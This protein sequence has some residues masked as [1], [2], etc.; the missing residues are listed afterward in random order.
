MKTG[1]LIS[2]LNEIKILAD[3]SLKELGSANAERTHGTPG[4]KRVAETS[5]DTLPTWILKLRAEGFFRQPKV[6][7]EVHEKLQ[8][9]YPCDPNRV[10][11]A[12]LRLHKRK[13]LRKTSRI[14][15]G[16]KQVAYVW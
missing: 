5:P 8:P 16:K 4:K 2:L 3:A 13:E 1:K 6:P 7:M 12:V 15:G 10:A 11:V 14:V 9:K